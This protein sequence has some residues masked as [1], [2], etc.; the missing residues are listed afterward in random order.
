MEELRHELKNLIVKLER[1]R[2]TAASPEGRTLQHLKSIQVLLEGEGHPMELGPAFNALK[3]F[4]LDAIAWC[5]A[6][7]RDIE[8]LIIIYGELSEENRLR[9]PPAG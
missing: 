2:P 5:S 7:S 1:G 8:K 6:L 4:W 9:Q 3:Q